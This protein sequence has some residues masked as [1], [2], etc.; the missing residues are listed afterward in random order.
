MRFAKEERGRFRSFLL[1]SLNHFLVHYWVRKTA[2]KRGGKERIISL[3]EGDAERIYN[4]E[5]HSVPPE[6]L[7]DKRWALTLLDRAIDRLRQ[8]YAKAGKGE[9]FESLSEW[10]S[11]DGTGEAYRRIAEQLDSTEGAIRVAVHRM[12]QR[13]GEAIRAEIADTVSSAEEVE[14]ELKTLMAALH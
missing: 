5:E 12:R 10:L 2:Q 7:Y 4:L 3:D 13:F 9:L 14:E 8:D 6:N 1:K 11:E